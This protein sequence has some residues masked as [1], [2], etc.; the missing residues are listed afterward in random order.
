MIHHIP[1]EKIDK[2]KWDYCIRNS[3]NGL[4][5]GYSWYLDII[6]EQWE[7]LILDDY[8][9]ICP[10]TQNKKFG[11]RYLY[12]PFFAQQLGIF[13]AEDIS[14]E[15]VTA[16]L[17]EIPKKFQHIEIHLNESNKVTYDD[18]TLIP[19]SNHCLHLDA[20]HEVIKN[21]YSENTLRNINK[22][23]KYELSIAKTVTNVQLIQLFKENQ[24]RKL[25]EYANHYEILNELIN[26]TIHRNMGELVGV[27]NKSRSLIGAV[28][29]LTS[30]Q[31]ITYLF[32][33]SNDEARSSGAMHFLMDSIIKEY[34]STPQIL[35]F[36]GSMITSIAR[37]YKSFGATEVLYPRLYR[38]KLPWY[39]NTVFAVYKKMR[40]L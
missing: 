9:V 38:N 23:T 27:Y 33:A 35:D 39:A 11:I 37:F 7:G 30:H 1:Y 6:C 34:A 19:R 22:A 18:R 25:K 31:R 40:G 29:L 28:F 14:E 10:L 12:Q 4:I 17:D 21:T 13:S 24:G 2:E 36:E 15:M 5:Y 8:K 26:E 3:L 32:P 20:D 16:F